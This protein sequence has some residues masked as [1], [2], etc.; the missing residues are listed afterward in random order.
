MNHSVINAR[1]PAWQ[2]LALISVLS[3]CFTPFSYAQANDGNLLAPIIVTASRFAS[4]PALA[5]I[6][7]S[8]ITAADIRHAGVDNVNQAIRNIGGVYGRS[9][10]YGTQDFDLDLRGFGTNSSQNLVVLVDGVRLSE[11]ELT[12]AQLS[13]IPIDT[14]ERIEIM[15]GGGS[16]LYGDGA[17]GGVIQIITKRPEPNALY[18]SATA[19]IGQYGHREI[20]TSIAKGWDGFALDASLSG[21]RADNYRANNA[22]RQENFSGGAQW[23]FTE[24]RAGLRI[25]LARQDSRFAGALSLAQFEADP[26][27]TL[28][29]NDYGSIDTDRYT[30]FVERRFGAWE[31]AAELSQRDKTI[32]SFFDYG[33]YGT[34]AADYESRQT[35][36]SPRL[37]KLDNLGG[38]INELVFGLDFGRW[39]RATR[40]SYSQADASQQSK[41]VYVRDEIKRGKIRLAAGARHEVFDK[42]AVDPASY[43]N[44]NYRTSQ[45]LNA[46]ELQAGYGAAPQLDLFAKAGQSY[47]VAN[48]DENAYTAL[49]N[50]PLQPQLSHDLE[51]GGSYGNVVRKLTVRLFRHRLH[52]EIFYDPTANGGYG[53]NANLDPTERKGLEVEVSARIADGVRLSAQ[54]QHVNA[55]FIDGVNAGKEVVMVPDNTLSARLNWLPADGQSANLGMQWASEQRYG[56]DFANTCP[57]LIPAHATLDGRYA[58]RIGA[59]EL[60]IAG[61][62]LTDKH[63]F[64]NAYGCRSGIYPSDGRQLKI[65]AR[66][67]F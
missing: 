55:R 50:T 4:D 53:A 54:W 3:A 19:E 60:A 66:H 8:V 36:F 44:I 30:A 15:R 31:A 5:P 42:D 61:S 26:R 64:S 27:Q 41:A 67:D 59:W 18:G 57:A 40:S 6:G 39:N 62:N 11:N 46:W 16:V 28:T 38:M 47:R 9:S 25:D 7:A 14:V 58:R 56:G 51:L 13:S 2:P 29:P 48:A 10:F 20:R 63:Y 24:G 23:T 35:Q 1:R 33:M 43:P 52:N 65:T 32:H 34:S 21:M 49:A 37:R 45:A 22:V 12:A 17:I